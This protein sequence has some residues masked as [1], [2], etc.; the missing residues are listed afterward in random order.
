MLF[1]ETYEGVLL[2]VARIAAIGPEHDGREGG[3]HRTITTVD[4][5]EFTIGAKAPCL[6]NILATI[7]KADPGYELLVPGCSGGEFAFYREPII[8]WRIGD[9]FMPEPITPVWRVSL[10]CKT[11][12]LC[13]D[14][15]VR[16]DSGNF[17]TLKEW[18][19]YGAKEH[20]RNAA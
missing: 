19:A 20:A 9:D 7:I 1:I 12:I 15:R 16:S 8:A 4:G 13:P 10:E 11:A 2:P 6:K 3:V 5:G 18:E 14:G 17:G